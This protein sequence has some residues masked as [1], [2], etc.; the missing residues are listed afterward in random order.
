M[1]LYSKE[2]DDKKAVN[3]LVESLTKLG[4]EMSHL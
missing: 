2:D 1:M 3:E 4:E